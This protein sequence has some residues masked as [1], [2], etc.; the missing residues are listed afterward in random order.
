MRILI[1]LT[2]LLAGCQSPRQVT[3]EARTLYASAKVEVV[4]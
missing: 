1:L 3:V 2:L 4:R